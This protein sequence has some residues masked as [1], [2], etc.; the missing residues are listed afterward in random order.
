VGSSI[1]GVL[2][3]GETWK[4]IAPSAAAVSAKPRSQDAN[5]QA[6]ASRPDHALAATEQ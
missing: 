1:L 6:R 5:T 2:F 3:G 4:R